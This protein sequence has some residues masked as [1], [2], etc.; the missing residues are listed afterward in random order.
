MAMDAGTVF[1]YV[2][3][4]FFLYLLCWIFIKPLKWLLRLGGSCLLGGVTIG[5]CNVLFSGLGWHLA[6]NP[7]TAMT[8][9]VLGIPG[10]ILARVLGS[11][12]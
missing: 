9:G 4:L 1:L 8:T 2:I 6:I 3:G 7:L 5:V 10:M 11:V 12:L